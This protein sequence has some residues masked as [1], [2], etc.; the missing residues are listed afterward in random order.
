M[1]GERFPHTPVIVVAASST[2]R[3]VQDALNAGA[4]GLVSADDAEERLAPA[5]RAVCAGLVAV[6]SE[7]RDPITRPLIS[8]RERQILSMVVLGFANREI[9]NKL[10]VAETTVKSHL[11]S[12]YR[13]LG[14]RSRQEATALVLDPKD[15]YGIGVLGLSE[16]EPLAPE[17]SPGG[18]HERAASERRRARVR[19]NSETHL[20]TPS[21]AADRL[22]VSGVSKTWER[23]PSSTMSISRSSRVTRAALVGANGAGKTTLLRIIA[24]LIAAD[25]GTVSARRIRRLGATVGSTSDVSA[26]SPPARPG[27]IL[28]SRSRGIS[29]TGHAWHSCPDVER[30]AAIERIIER[31]DLGELR[32]KRPDRLSMGQRQRVRLAMGFLHEPHLVRAGRA[33]HEPRSA[34]H[35]GAEPRSRGL[36]SRRGGLRS[37]VRRR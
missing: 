21:R 11:S 35:G 9:A 4:R 20:L 14:V 27:S 26:S 22:L 23:R 8:P 37:G 24:G 25:S 30:S 12:V 13:K 16:G 36:T 33:S 28:A 10:Y 34:R 19:E 5:V 3:T 29:N 2:R 15:G 7:L 18:C 17:L 31:F 1:L 6:P 32:L